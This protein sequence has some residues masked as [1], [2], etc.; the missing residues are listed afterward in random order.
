MHFFETLRSRPFFD[1]CDL[2]RIDPDTIDSNDEA[3]EFGF[4]DVKFTFLWVCLKSPF[5]KLS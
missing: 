5:L 1:G 4:L 3:E 2:R